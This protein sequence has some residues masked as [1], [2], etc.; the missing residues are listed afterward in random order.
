MREVRWLL[1]IVRFLRGPMTQRRVVRF[2][3]GI[4][5]AIILYAVQDA[6]RR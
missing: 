6:V 2:G 4:V 3:A 1:R 5:V